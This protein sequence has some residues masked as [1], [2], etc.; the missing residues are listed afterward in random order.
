MSDSRTNSAKL[1]IPRGRR[2]ASVGRVRKSV[3]RTSRVS[4]SN[5]AN[6]ALSCRFLCSCSSRMVSTWSSFCW[7]RSSLSSTE[8]RTCAHACLS[9]SCSLGSCGWRGICLERY[10]QQLATQ[11]ANFQGQVRE[12]QVVEAVHSHLFR[13]L[14][15][16]AQRIGKDKD[17]SA[18][19]RK[20][21]GGGG[22]GAR[23]FPL[24]SRTSCHAVHSFLELAFPVAKRVSS[25][26]ISGKVRQFLL[27]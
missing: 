25:L 11:R 5:R 17:A 2:R 10:P 14:K 26:R 15:E 22:R 13:R 9:R 7:R 1:G 18:K 4:R 20:Q 21:G 6:S 24:F 16:R 8:A 3:A 23:N 19:R 27:F 12:L